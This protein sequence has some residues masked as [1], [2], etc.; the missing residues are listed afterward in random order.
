M[1]T[2]EFNLIEIVSVQAETL[3]EA[4]GKLIQGDYKFEECQSEL[5]GEEE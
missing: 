3:E 2:Y 1:K 5:R 4:W